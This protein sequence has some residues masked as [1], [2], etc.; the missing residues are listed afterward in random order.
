MAIVHEQRSDTGPIAGRLA[1]TA[2]SGRARV[3]SIGAALLCGLAFGTLLV[4]AYPRQL[5]IPLAGDPGSPFA[6]QGF[7]SL[8]RGA[9]VS[10]AW[11]GQRAQISLPGVDR[12]VEWRWSARVL[13]W[14]PPNQRATV[15]VAVD[16]VVQFTQTLGPG[17]AAIEVLLPPRPGTTGATLTI[18]TS[19]V[20]VPGPGDRRELG[21]AIESPTIVRTEGRP[22]PPPTAIAYGAGSILLIGVALAFVELPWTWALGALLASGSALV[23][24]FQRGFAA[25]TSYPWRTAVLAA[26]IGTGVVLSARVLEWLRASRLSASACAVAAF[27]AVASYLKLLILLHPT[28]PFGDGI[29]HAHRFE[30]VLHGRFYFTSI[31]P[32]NYS[33]PY[34]ILLYLVAA[35]FSWLAHDTVERA[36]LLRIVVTVADAGAGATLYWMIVRSTANRYAGL[37]AVFW[38][39]LIPMTAWIM[40]WGNLT[41]AF[42]QTLFVASVA[43]VVAVPV[44]RN[45]RS[46][47]VLT[48]LAAAALLSHPSTCAIL[49][50]VLGVTT[51]LY[52]WRGGSLLAGSAFAIRSATIAAGLI[53]LVVYYGWFPAL[54]A[55]ELSRVVAESG[56][57]LASAAPD[58]PISSRLALIPTLAGEYLGWPALIAAAVGAWRIRVDVQDPRL[59]WLLAGWAGACVL[60]LFLGVVTPVQMRTH[61]ALFPAMAVSAAFGCLWAWRGSLPL[62]VGAMIIMGTAAWVG[63]RQW[64][65]LLGD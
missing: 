1:G 27:S 26:G 12:R 62:R 10:F 5:P 45:R 3:R 63:I 59:A 23:L 40:T 4:T 31:A 24:L 60:F 50:V 39:H 20:F 25:H 35:P 7:Y 34:P 55:R 51:V 18:D 44:D 38:Y 32:G 8:E 17:P 9:G 47:L 13:P 29:F 48:A 53:A 52:A 15:R 46:M 56:T 54:Y 58:S 6:T 64:I 65:A 36:A 2:A 43:A 14:R 21:V 37:G 28:A 42:G 30:Y 22:L 11:T 16:G 33:F 49:M 41:N 19:P 57:H 61:F